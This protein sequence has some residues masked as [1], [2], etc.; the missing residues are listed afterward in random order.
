MLDIAVYW[1][2]CFRLKLLCS[3]RMR[4]GYCFQGA[5]VQNLLC[6][7]K[8]DAWCSKDVSRRITCVYGRGHTQF[9]CVAHCGLVRATRGTALLPTA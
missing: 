9:V 4:R 8:G 1:T 6:C 3:G 7:M 2:V 5:Q